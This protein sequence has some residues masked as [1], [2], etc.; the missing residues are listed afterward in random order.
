[1]AEPIQSDAQGLSGHVLV[2]DDTPA[3]RELLSDLLQAQGHRV[4]EAADGD[5]ALRKAAAD[6]PDV[7]LLD[8]MMPGTSGFEVC[9]RLKHDPLTAP[10]PVLMITSLH[11]RAERLRGIEAGANDYLT[12]PIDKADVLLRVRN[13]IL[14]KR[15]H[16]RVQEDLARVKELETLRDNLTHM[17]VHDMRSPLTVAAGAY[18]IMLTERDR[19]SQTQ[20]EFAALGQNSCRELIEMVSSL[21]DVS[22]MEAGQMPLNRDPCDLRDIARKATQSVVVLAREKKLTMQVSGDPSRASVDRDI[23]HRV[24]VNLLGNAIKFSPKDGTIEVDVSCAGE[25]VRVTVNDQGHGIPSEFHQR[26]FDKFGQV[27]SR[28]QDKKLSTGLGLTFCKL[29]VEAHGGHIGVESQQG[30]GSTF[31]ITIPIGECGGA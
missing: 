15:L 10:I 3:N 24:L 21:L 8:V 1:M 19:L 28:K 27:Q 11:E 23:M 9:R 12:K 2:V 6:P 5:D 14:T 16:A 17:I 4:T 30:K 31:W 26:I 7:V 18:E 13:A 22:R 25:T 20:L 29:A